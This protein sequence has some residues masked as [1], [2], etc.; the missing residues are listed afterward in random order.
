MSGKDRLEAELTLDFDIPRNEW[1]TQNTT[2]HL[3]YQAHATRARRIRYRAKLAGRK[4]RVRIR[5]PALIVATTFYKAGRGPDDDAAAPVIKALKDGLTDAGVW[6][7]DN[8]DYVAGTLY[9]RS[10]RDSTLKKGWHRIR[11]QIISEWTPF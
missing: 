7:D 8:G 5:P 3:H 10:R 4:T 11:L 2:R 6:A 9:Q 1:M